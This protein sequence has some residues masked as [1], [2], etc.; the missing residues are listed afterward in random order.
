M[1]PLSFWSLREVRIYVDAPAQAFRFWEDIG[2]ADLHALMSLPRLERLFAEQIC[3]TSDLEFDHSSASA[4]RP[5]TVKHLHL[6]YVKCTA[7][8]L[9]SL[10]DRMT[11]LRSLTLDHYTSDP[12]TSGQIPRCVEVHWATMMDFRIRVDRNVPLRGWSVERDLTPDKRSRL[13]IDLGHLSDLLWVL[14]LALTDDES[15]GFLD[16]HPPRSRRTILTTWLADNV[17]RK[18]QCLRFVD[19][20]GIIDIIAVDLDFVLDAFLRDTP[21]DLT[22]VLD[23]SKLKTRTSWHADLFL[24]AKVTKDL[25][26]TLLTPGGCG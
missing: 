12:E 16:G 6:G 9:C 26:I 22:D 7:P 3:A 4:Q 5:S 15:S 20:I 23:L 1:W 25:G 14:P 24:T 17:P 19:T 2:Y 18:A 10:L 21:D 11:T 13:T 8:Q